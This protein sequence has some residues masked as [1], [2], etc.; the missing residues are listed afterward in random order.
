MARDFYLT[1]RDS[2]VHL[3]N[4]S[5]LQSTFRLRSCLDSEI[6]CWRGLLLLQF[7]LHCDAMGY[8]TFTV[9]GG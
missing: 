1:L 7:V 9:P 6:H 8:L 2:V 3:V 5:R 4:G